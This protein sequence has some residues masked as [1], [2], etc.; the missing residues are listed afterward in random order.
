MSDVIARDCNDHTEKL[1]FVVETKRAMGISA[2]YERRNSGQSRERAY[3]K[4]S[5]ATAY[6]GYEDSL[7]M[8]VYAV[9]FAG[10]QSSPI[11]GA[12]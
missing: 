8:C 1:A 10:F 9:F 3:L 5:T 7:L 12:K 6:E 2:E 4:A 11:K